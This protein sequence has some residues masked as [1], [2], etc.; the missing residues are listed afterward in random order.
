MS[1]IA[2]CSCRV[3][4]DYRE[5]HADQMRSVK[6]WLT[7]ILCD[8]LMK[9]APKSSLCDNHNYVIHECI[10][11]SV[12]RASKISN[13][14]FRS[15]MLRK[16]I[17][18][19]FVGLCIGLFRVLPVFATIG[20]L[21]QQIWYLHANNGTRWRRTIDDVVEV[22]SLGFLIKVYDFTCM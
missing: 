19:S 2:I 13:H 9:L 8:Q 18:C 16:R 1:I 3:Y 15:T 12:R 22:P 14:F 6:L 7:Y 11:R 4:I 21:I 5:K 20:M 10:C 17:K